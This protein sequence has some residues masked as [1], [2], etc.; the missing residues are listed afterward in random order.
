MALYH[1]ILKPSGPSRLRLA[2]KA[3]ILPEFHCS[4]STLESKKMII[5]EENQEDRLK[6]RDCGVVTARRSVKW[7][8]GAEIL[9]RVDAAG[10]KADKAG[11]GI[12][13]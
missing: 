5:I 7:D 10:Q 11:I 1:V 6:K 9:S 4:T 12:A 3:T 8:D 13:R 2:E